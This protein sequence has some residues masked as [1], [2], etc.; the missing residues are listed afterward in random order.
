MNRRQLMAAVFAA[1]AVSVTGVRAMAS[2]RIEDLPAE[3]AIEAKKWGWGPPG[4][5][6]GWGRGNSGWAATRGRKRGWY[7]HRGRGW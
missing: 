3:G 4:H 2:E 5:A 7:K 6:R 1:A